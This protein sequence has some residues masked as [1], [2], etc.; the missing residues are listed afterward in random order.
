MTTPDQET[1]RLL[2]FSLA[3]KELHD[4][5]DRV[6]AFPLH[7]Q[8]LL[9]TLGTAYLSERKTKWW[10]VRGAK[11]NAFLRHDHA[12]DDMWIYLTMFTSLERELRWSLGAQPLLWRGPVFDEVA[13]SLSNEPLDVPVIKFRQSDL[14][15][16]DEARAMLFEAWHPTAGGT[17]PQ[18]EGGPLSRYLD[19][20]VSN[21]HDTP[22]P[23]TRCKTA[24]KPARR[25][26]QQ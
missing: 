6:D 2:E 20:Y 5:I 13:Y 1:K 8:T 16:S 12:P 7:A 17:L 10:S 26:R 19:A 23:F 24:I 15:Q 9:R 4:A 3:E 14:L 22:P 11:A 21:I 25:G 18:R